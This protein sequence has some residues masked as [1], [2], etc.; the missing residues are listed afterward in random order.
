MGFIMQQQGKNVNDTW[1]EQGKI[2]STL[3]KWR[4]P[5]YNNPYDIHFD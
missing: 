1:C 2:L 3:G 5:C 4:L